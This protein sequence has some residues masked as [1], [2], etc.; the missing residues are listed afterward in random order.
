MI[1][2]HL[3]TCRCTAT[4][5]VQRFIVGAALAFG[6]LPAHAQSIDYGALEQL[7]GEPVTTS[8]TG[9]P[10]R[11]SDAPANMV[12]ITQADIR[13]SGADN[14]P[15]VL[16]YVAGI[17]V[18]R[19]SYSQAEVSVR[20]YDQQYSP[21]LLVLI[22]G[23][24]VYLDDYGYTAWQTLPVQLE[25]I[26][27]IEVVKGPSSALFGFNAVGGVINI[28]TYDPLFDSVDDVTV[29]S[30]TD[31]YRAASAV[32]TLRAPGRAGLRISAG[33]SRADE[34]STAGLPASTGPYGS[35]PSRYGISA[36]G[37]LEVT[38][39]MELTAEATSSEARSLD[40]SP[41]LTPYSVDYRTNSGKLGLNADTSVGLIDLQAYR[42]HFTYGIASPAFMLADDLFVLKASDLFRLGSTHTLRLGVEYRGDTMSQAGSQRVGDRVYGASA[43]WSWRM[44]SQLALTNSVRV[45]RLAMTFKDTVLPVSQFNRDADKGALTAVSFNSGLVYTPTAVDTVRLLLGRGVQAPS[46][47]DLGLQER[48]PLGGGLTLTYS[49]NP[50]LR[51]ATVMNYEI[52]YDR[53]LAGLESKL[54]TAIYYQR[55]GDLLAGALETPLAAVPGGLVAYSR[56]VGGSD[57]AGGEIGLEGK[58]PSGLRWNASYARI[59]ISQNLTLGALRGT[60]RLLD[61]AHG[62]PANVVDVGLG[63]GA[64]RLEVDLEGRW[65]SRFTDYA[66]NDLGVIGA[67]PVNGYFTLSARVAYRLTRHLTASLAGEQ[68]GRERIFEA[69][70]T[71][72]ERR[73]YG[74]IS[75]KF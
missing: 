39:R 52:D 74:T 63:Y 23:R 38:S 33:G 69:A 37:R 34:F 35:S 71:P 73:V 65:Q 32:G 1:R 64:R 50:D 11:A 72:V 42:N 12:I 70:G 22:N 16:Q 2:F 24:Q 6:V 9:S 7:F 61:Y 60:S 18:R 41:L 5:A 17:D 66:P 10:Q 29:R 75:A 30:G 54:R 14:I 26:R 20:G 31:G 48:Y 56:N 4:P 43:M 21:R 55:T 68:L 59:S 62:S 8:A 44:A 40:T 51:P 53:Q 15:D 19:Y 28:V 46:L 49:G 36:D 45:D 25:E 67:F 3:L 27:Q 57:A 47:A 13:R 58:D